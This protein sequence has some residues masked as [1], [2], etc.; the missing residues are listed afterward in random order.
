MFYGANLVCFSC[1][2]FG[3]ISPYVC[4]YHF[5]SVRVAE[6]P[7]FRQELLTR[8]TMCSVCILTICNFSFPRIGFE[9]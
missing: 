7:P 5:S 4:S 6:Y 8:Y 3:D 2:S 9:G 1:Q